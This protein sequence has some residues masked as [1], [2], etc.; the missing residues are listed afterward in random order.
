MVTLGKVLMLGGLGL[1]LAGAFLLLIG[2]G[3]LPGIPAAWRPGHLPGDWRWQSP[4]GAVRIYVPLGTSL[5]LSLLL[6]FLW[7][8]F[9]RRS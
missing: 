7:W 9:S 3:V 1:V 4:S 5:L 2:K 8:L 6:S